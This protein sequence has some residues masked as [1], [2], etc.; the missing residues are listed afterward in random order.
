MIDMKALEREETR[1]ETGRTYA[2]DYRLCLKNRG[3]DPSIVD[4]LLELNRARKKAIQEVES[5][6][7]YQGKVG[8]TI[9]Q[10]KR[11]KENADAELAEMQAVAAQIKDA[12]TAAAEAETKVQ[13]MVVRLPNMLHHTVPVGKTDADNVVVHTYGE[14]RNFGFK[15]KEHWELGEALGQIDF[16]RAGKVTGARFVF[17]K[18][19]V[20]QM[21]RALISFMLDIHTREH[22][23]TEILP[24]F[25]INGQ[26]LFGTGN[27][28][29]FFDDVFHL[30]GTD[31]HLAPTAEVPVTN[32]FRDETLNEE[33]LPHCFAAYS[34][35][36]RS[37]A[38][39]YGKDTRGLIR[40]HQFEKVELMKFAHPAASYENHEKL[41]QNAE[42]ILKR[43]ELPFQRVTLCTGD[44]SFGAAKCY[45]LNV[46]LPG[47][48]AYRE[49]SSCSNF[50]D[51]QARRANIR[52]K[53]KGGGKP[54]FVHTINGSGLAIGRTVIAIM[55]NYQ[56]ED[57]SVLVPKAL[58]SYMG[59]T[60]K[61]SKTRERG[62]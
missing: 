54:Q 11:D 37:E 16:E 59:G 33:E 1:P 13:D 40:Q 36:F 35:C 43:L 5:K 31:Y 14:P 23:Y 27:F 45:D 20:A 19:Q 4:Q 52:F 7:A 25:M 21:E 41:T 26:S 58:Q 44:I 39:S 47:Q 2:D 9:A 28:P 8:L 12:E 49:I 22:G 57:G 38:G 6:K 55:E 42:T 30:A 56:Q 50:E 53:P 18:G 24:P 3:A 15:A 62:P 46:W 10:K 51:F 17:L 60:S 48:N 34:P 32:Y 61:I 29:K